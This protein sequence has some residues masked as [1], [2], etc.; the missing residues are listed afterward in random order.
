MFTISLTIKYEDSECKDSVSLYVETKKLE[1]KN[2]LEINQQIKGK[3]L[4]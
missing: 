3:S 2:D 1:D 4:I